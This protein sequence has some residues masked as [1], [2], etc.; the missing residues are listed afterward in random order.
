MSNETGATGSSSA[1]PDLRAQLRKARAAN[2]VLL[3]D[4]IENVQAAKDLV[5]KMRADLAELGKEK[6]GLADRL[7]TARRQIEMEQNSRQAEREWVH[8][9]AIDAHQHVMLHILRRDLPTMNTATDPKAHAEAFAFW[10]GLIVFLD[11][12][13]NRTRPP[14]KIDL[15][16]AE[17]V[18]GE[19]KIMGV[20]MA[21]KGV[22]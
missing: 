20:W 21:E 19:A 6:E 13:Q 22:E 15:K 12:L 10:T 11:A 1:V 7:A 4:A 14:E 8:K 3:K 16:F 9:H 18:G 2:R 17:G 5:E